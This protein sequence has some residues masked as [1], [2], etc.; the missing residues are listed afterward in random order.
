MW[1]YQR[2]LNLKSIGE[3]YNGKDVDRIIMLKKKN[4]ILCIVLKQFSFRLDDY[5]VFTC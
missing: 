5:A 4:F 2:I 1:L 3:F